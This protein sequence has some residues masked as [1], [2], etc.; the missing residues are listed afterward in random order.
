[1]LSF[2]AEGSELNTL[3]REEMANKLK[4][5]NLLVSRQTVSRTL[6]KCKQTHKRI[7]YKPLEQKWSEIERFREKTKHLP[8]TQFSC[9]DEF[10]LYLN[11]I[12]NYATS[13]IGKRAWVLK[14]NR[15]SVRLGNKS[16][17]I[18]LIIC[19]QRTEKK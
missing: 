11:S 2:T 18:T 8:L 7:S 3:T 5:K 13:P 19:V 4:E 15:K 1:L 17:S 12:P 6:K 9:L 10:P 14:P 16:A